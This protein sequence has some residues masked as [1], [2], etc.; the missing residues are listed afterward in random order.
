MV[1]DYVARSS[2]SF[3]SYKLQQLY[4]AEKI[5][6]SHTNFQ[7]S[8]RLCIEISYKA[9]PEISSAA[10]NLFPPSQ[11]NVH[12]NIYMT[13]G[14][15]A[16]LCM[17]LTG[18]QKI[19]HL[20]SYIDVWSTTMMPNFQFSTRALHSTFWVTELKFENQLCSH[21]NSLQPLVVEW[22]S[23]NLLTKMTTEYF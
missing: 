7:L 18:L 16:S 23:D 5:Q 8:G 14:L 4:P 15:S 6:L 22:L 20:C 10:T 2:S 11:H 1:P 12:L 19:H 13:K 9:H 3:I 21:H 17:F